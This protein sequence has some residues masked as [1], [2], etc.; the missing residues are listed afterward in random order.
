MLQED[1]VPTNDYDKCA[2]ISINGTDRNEKNSLAEV[3]KGNLYY[4]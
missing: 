1:G 3:R 4:L 2:F